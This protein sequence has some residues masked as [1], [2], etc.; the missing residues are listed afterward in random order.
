MSSKS[1]LLQYHCCPA[2]QS[3]MYYC[4]RE[5]DEVVVPPQVIYQLVI[6]NNLF[7]YELQEIVISRTHRPSKRLFKKSKSAFCIMSVTSYPL[8]E[9]PTRTTGLIEGTTSYGVQASCFLKNGFFFSLP[10]G[11]APAPRPLPAESD[12]SPTDRTTSMEP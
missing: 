7:R 1:E 4:S 10:A 11:S 9:G 6:N 2:L 3:E 8:S 5:I 12:S